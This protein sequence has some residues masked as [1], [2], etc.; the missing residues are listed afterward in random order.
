MKIKKYFLF[1]LFLITTHINATDLNVKKSCYQ[2]IKEFKELQNQ[3]PIHTDMMT[4]IV[5][6]SS[7]YISSEN[8][9]YTT[10]TSN[11]LIDKLIKSTNIS[12]NKEIKMQNYFNSIEGENEIIDIINKKFNKKIKENGFPKKSKGFT[13]KEIYSFPNYNINTVILEHNY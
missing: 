8:R 5:G 12:E 7:F 6:I 4:T 3:L 11:I 1:I 9:C 10:F 13:F 2:L